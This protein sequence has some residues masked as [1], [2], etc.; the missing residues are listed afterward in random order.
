MAHSKNFD[1]GQRMTELYILNLSQVQFL[2]NDIFEFY[3]KRLYKLTKFQHWHK[4]PF[5][6]H[7]KFFL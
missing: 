3:K 7:P 6:T 2:K 1:F 5:W 4:N